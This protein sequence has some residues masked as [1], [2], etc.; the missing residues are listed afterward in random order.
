M[1]WQRGSFLCVTFAI[2]NSLGASTDLKTGK[3][4]S[5]KVIGIKVTLR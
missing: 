2:L 4:Y 3:E 1:G 5:A